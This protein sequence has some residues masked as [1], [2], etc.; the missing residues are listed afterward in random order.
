MRYTLLVGEAPG[1]LEHLK[2]Y[3]PLVGRCSQFLAQLAMMDHADFLSRTIRVNLFNT[4]VKAK[5]WDKAAAAKNL[6]RIVS[7]QSYVK[8]IVLLGQRVQAAAGKTHLRTIGFAGVALVKTGRARI[9]NLPHPS[10]RC[11]WWNSVGNRTIACAIL[12][13][14]LLEDV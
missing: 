2:N 9:Y 7:S 10:G 14:A 11:R 4:I 3:D 13:T 6:E 8:T 1:R 12:R 5:D